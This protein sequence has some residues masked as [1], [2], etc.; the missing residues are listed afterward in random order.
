MRHQA[1]QAIIQIGEA[2]IKRCL[3]FRSGGGCRFRIAE[4]VVV[5]PFDRIAGTA[6]KRFVHGGGGA[7]H[8]F[9]QGGEIGGHGSGLGH[10]GI[11]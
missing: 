4:I 8:A 1:L 10:A 11:R 2:G 3:C 6:D 7:G 9:P 5:D